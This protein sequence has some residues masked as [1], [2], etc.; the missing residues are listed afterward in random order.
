MFIELTFH[1]EIPT[2]SNFDLILS[3][4]CLVVSR[5]DADFMAEAGDGIIETT[6]YTLKLEMPFENRF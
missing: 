2:L 3:Q 5:L 1:R 6:A 4:I